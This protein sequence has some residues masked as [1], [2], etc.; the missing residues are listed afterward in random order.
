[1]AWLNGHPPQGNPGPSRYL[2]EYSYASSEPETDA[3]VP[4][5]EPVLPRRLEPDPTAKNKDKLFIRAKELEKKWNYKD[6][7]RRER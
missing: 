6:E 1:M 3:A 5:F 4:A 7:E 2:W